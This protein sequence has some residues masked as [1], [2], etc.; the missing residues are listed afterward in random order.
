MSGDHPQPW[1]SRNPTHSRPTASKPAHLVP[2]QKRPLHIQAAAGK[3]APNQ[4]TQTLKTWPSLASGPTPRPPANRG[5]EGLTSP[6]LLRAPSPANRGGL[7]TLALPH[8]QGPAPS[9]PSAARARGTV[10]VFRSGFR[11]CL[12]CVSWK[13]EAAVAEAGRGLAPRV[14]NCASQPRPRGAG[15]PRGRGALLS[16]RPPRSPPS[17]APERRG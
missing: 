5:G 6:P 4:L 2:E 15:V 10:V 11:G 9:R 3:C 17:P 7:D 8:A 16:L 12:A 1:L 14:G 13:G